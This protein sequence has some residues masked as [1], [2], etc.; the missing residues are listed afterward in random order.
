[1]RPG[2]L[3][4]S[5]GIIM[6]LVGVF[7]F[8][9]PDI[10]FFF[11][12]MPFIGIYYFIKGIIQLIQSRNSNR[13]DDYQI[14][15]DSL[16]SFEGEDWKGWIAGKYDNRYGDA[17]RYDYDSN[18][19]PHRRTKGVI[20]FLCIVLIFGISLPFVLDVINAEEQLD[21]LK[22]FTILGVNVYG[23]YPDDVFRQFHEITNYRLIDNIIAY[24][25][26]DNIIAYETVDNTVSDEVLHMALS[27]WTDINPELEFMNSTFAE[28]EIIS[29]EINC[30]IENSNNYRTIKMCE[31]GHYRSDGIIAVVGNTNNPAD[32]VKILAHEIGHML[33]LDHSC[34]PSHLMYD[35]SGNCNHNVYFEDL[36]YNIPVFEQCLKMSD[37]IVYCT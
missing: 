27:S 29:V 37:D 35:G 18:F 11:P 4:L 31:F 26:V 6:I 22:R 14:D 1:M 23:F 7:T 9:I 20:K 36:G 21:K 28:I 3:S 8:R 19:T 34:V 2:A 33:G 10:P 24:E 17:N 16:D 30:E 25:V 32:Q 13:Y 15:D 5:I 12:L